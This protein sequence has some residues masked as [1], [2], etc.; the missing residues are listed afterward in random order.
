M[1]EKINGPIGV[2]LARV[3]AGVDAVGKNRRNEAQR[4]AFRGID[5]FMNTLHPVLAEHGIVL[6][7]VVT[8][9]TPLESQETKSG[10]LMFRVLVTMDVGFCAPDGTAHVVTTVGEGADTGDKATNKAMSAALKYALV[11][12]FLIPTEDLK[13][14]EED[15][16]E[17]KGPAPKRAP[18]PPNGRPIVTRAQLTEREQAK[19]MEEVAILLQLVG[20]NERQKAA[21]WL[22]KGNDPRELLPRLRVLAGEA[23]ARDDRPS[24]GPT[25]RPDSTTSSVNSSAGGGPQSGSQTSLPSTSG[26]AES[27]PPSNPNASTDP[28]RRRPSKPGPKEH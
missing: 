25:G 1:S 11:M 27:A 23:Q 10:G 8:A 26:A 13:D 16:H 7:P 15:S 3:M 6:R 12:T 4:Y 2:L 21:A 19:V 14:S 20:H 5:D 18:P 17:A 22:S 9:A 28:T 24:P